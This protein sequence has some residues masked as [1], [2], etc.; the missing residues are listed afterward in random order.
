MACTY[1]SYAEDVLKEM[2]KP[3]TVPRTVSKVEG[4]P[5][6]TFEPPGLAVKMSTQA[7]TIRILVHCNYAQT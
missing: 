5:M 7:T 4:I 3:R 1:L 6:F 2:T